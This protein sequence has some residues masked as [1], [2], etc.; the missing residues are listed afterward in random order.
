[1]YYYLSDWAYR[2]AV[3]QG[4]EYCQNVELDDRMG[5]VTISK[6]NTCSDHVAKLLFVATKKTL[7][8]IRIRLPPLDEPKMTR[9][10]AELRGPN[11]RPDFEKLEAV[12]H[13]I[14]LKYLRP[15]NLTVIRKTMIEIIRTELEFLFALR[16]LN[17]QL[18][19]TMGELG[20]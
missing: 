10:Q 1:M 18:I 14:L 11:T 6:V 15:S 17:L 3:H 9:F 13:G 2:H 7:V 16:I 8:N 4:R 12:P 19:L 5:L 20:L